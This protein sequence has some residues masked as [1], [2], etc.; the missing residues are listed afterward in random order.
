MA[1]Y[2]SRLEYEFIEKKCTD[3]C[4]GLHW[5][6]LDPICQNRS[7]RIPKLARQ[8]SR[9]QGL[10]KLVFF[11]RDL[12]HVAKP[13]FL[14]R[15]LFESNRFQLV[16]TWETCKLRLVYLY[17]NAPIEIMLGLLKKTSSAERL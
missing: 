1:Y 16:S 8:V 3:T 12:F 6:V 5:K 7:S 14:V 4:N 11:V 9:F 10:A 15:D 17:C 2:G 13:V